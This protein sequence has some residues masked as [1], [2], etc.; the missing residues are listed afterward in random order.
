MLIYA[1]RLI[2]LLIRTLTDRLR[3]ETDS[4]ICSH[5]CCVLYRDRKLKRDAPDDKRQCGEKHPVFEM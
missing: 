2:E 1:K 4:Q 3:I 5:A